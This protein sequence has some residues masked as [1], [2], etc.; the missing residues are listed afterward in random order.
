MW[1]CLIILTLIFKNSYSR[2]RSHFEDVDVRLE[3]SAPQETETEVKNKYNNFKECSIDDN[4]E[5]FSQLQG[6][7]GQ[8]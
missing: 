3:D 7:I 2:C 1:E 5:K 4:M 8:L 6:T